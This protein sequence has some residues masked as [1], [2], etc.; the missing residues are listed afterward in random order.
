M[1][2][3]TLFKHESD[4]HDP[5]AKVVFTCMIGIAFVQLVAER[6]LDFVILPAAL[7]NKMA[8]YGPEN[9]PTGRS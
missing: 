2:S 1:S 3:G 5:P 7:H 4:I 9:F 8:A 6:S